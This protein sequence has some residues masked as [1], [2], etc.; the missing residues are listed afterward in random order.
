ME[1]LEGVSRGPKQFQFPRQ[2]RTTF[3]GNLKQKTKHFLLNQKENLFS[4]EL[5]K[6]I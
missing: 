4:P 5:W 2:I 1:K 6:E 3:P